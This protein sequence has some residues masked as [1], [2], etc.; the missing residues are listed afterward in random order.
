MRGSFRMRLSHAE[1]NGPSG[2]LPGEGLLHLP[3]QDILAVQVARRE[4]QRDEAADA[5]ATGEA[6]GLPRGEMAAVRAQGGILVQERRLDEELVG[7]WASSRMRAMLP[8][9]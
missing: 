5:G 4:M 1:A 7:A 6:S 8:S 9:W 3:S 2:Q